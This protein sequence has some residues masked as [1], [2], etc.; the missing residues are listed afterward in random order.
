MSGPP[1]TPW[2]SRRP[3][4]R[5]APRSRTRWQRARAGG[6][7]RRADPGRSRCGAV[8]PAVQRAPHRAGPRG[9][10][11][12]RRAVRRGAARAGVRRADRAGR[13]LADRALRAGPSGPTDGSTGCG[14][15][16]WSREV[17][18][19]VALGLR[20]GRTASRAVGYAQVLEAL[21][22]RDRAGPGPRTD[23]PGDPAADP[24]AGVV[25]P[26]RPADPVARRHGAGSGRVRPCG[27]VGRG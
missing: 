2:R 13:L 16:A 1:S 18:R 27:S 25:V 6:A 21:D 9:D 12:D 7:A 5:S 20:D 24:P 4:R 19:L 23:G 8:D 10:R 15:A 3:T 26:P 14:S 22:G 11:A 17:E